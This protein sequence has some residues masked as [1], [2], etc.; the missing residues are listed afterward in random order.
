[1]LPDSRLHYPPGA[2]PPG[3]QPWTPE[4]DQSGPLRVVPPQPPF[5]VLVPSFL[6][7]PGG[8]VPPQAS[9]TLVSAATWD[10]M[11]TAQFAAYDVILIPECCPHFLVPSRNVWGAAVTGPTVLT[12]TH[13]PLYGLNPAADQTSPI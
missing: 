2:V 12:T 10:G 3:A 8:Y 4:N 9:V 6:F 1:M 13:L 7:V 11:T 5:T